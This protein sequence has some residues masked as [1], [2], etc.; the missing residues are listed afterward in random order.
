MRSWGAG[1]VTLLITTLAQ[2]QTAPA[3][4]PTPAPQAQPAPPPYHYPPPQPYPYP[5]PQPYPYAY[6]YA[7][8]QLP[9]EM[10]YDPEKPIPPGYKVEE[11]VR[12]GAVISGAIILGVPYVIGLNSA[13]A[14]GF[15]NK[16]YWLI[17]PGIGPFLTLSTRDDS[18]DEDPNNSSKEAADCLG[19][20]FIN[21]LLV[22]DGLMQTAGGVVLTVGL[23]AKKQWLVREQ[24]PAA[25]WR[26]AP[27]R[28]GRQ[29][30]GFGVIGT[31]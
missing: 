15:E 25:S 4:A 24:A 31:F 20:V 28:V 6:P 12:K 27:M 23:T 7:P 29:G 18:C 19:D 1:A 17:V 13:A 11:R 30:Q 9:A 2:A 8:Q 14:A 3:P 22:L 5:P 16:S 10:P 26:L 21:M